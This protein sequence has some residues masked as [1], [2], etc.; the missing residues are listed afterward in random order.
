MT[1]Q[2]AVVLNRVDSDLFPDTIV[3]VIYQNGAFDAVRDGQYYLTPNETAV[4]AAKDA[5]NGW[6]PA[7]GALYYWNPVT[8]TSRWIWSIPIQA[9]IGRHVFG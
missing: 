2:G 6:D 3:E 7:G 4:Q 5:L 8:A 9:R 1:A